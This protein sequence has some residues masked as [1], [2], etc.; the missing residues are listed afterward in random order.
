MPAEPRPSPVPVTPPP[1]VP[2]FDWVTHAVQEGDTLF[3]LAERYDTDVETLKQV[4]CLESDV[5]VIDRE[6]FVPGS[7]G[8]N[9]IAATADALENARSSAEMRAGVPE[10]FLNIV[11]LG[12]DK[13]AGS[14]TWRTDTIIIV[15]I[16]AEREAVRLLSIPRDLWVDVP[17]HGYDRINTADLWGELAQE[18][19][20]PDLVKETVYQSL[21]I[22]IHYYVRVDFEGFIKIIDAIGGVDID[23]ECPLSDIELASGVQHMDGKLALLYA[24]SRITTND[25]DRARRQRKLLMALWEQGLTKDIIPRLP[26]LWMAMSDTIETDLPLSRI[27]GLAPM[28]LRLKPNQIF[29]QSIGP[30]QVENWTTP[31]GASVLLPRQDEIQELLTSFYGPIDT[32]FLEQISQTRIQVLNASRIDQADQLVS[33]ALGWAGFQVTD[34]G[35]ADGQVYTQT[36]I[37]LYNAGEDIAEVVAQ[38]LEAPPSA[39]QYEPDPSSPVDILVVLGADYDPCK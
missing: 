10:D 25:F 23:V 11:L 18:G 12:S 7:A 8:A 28:G 22:P 3:S 19:G 39:I 36:Q 35:L 29:S 38:E 27:I 1:C 15:S 9:Q 32:A 13:R 6:L 20:G 34:T 37:I 17:G 21:R 24:R 33:T 2:P 26:A 16:D 5:I 31:Q 4:N 30:W 14:A